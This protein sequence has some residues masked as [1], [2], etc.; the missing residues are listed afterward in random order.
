MSQCSIYKNT[1][2]GDLYPYDIQNGSIRFNIDNKSI[3]SKTITNNIDLK[4]FIFDPE[5]YWK[6]A[7]ITDENLIF[8]KAILGKTQVQ[9]KVL[10]IEDA[11][12][13][14][15]VLKNWDISNNTRMSCN[16]FISSM[17]G[18]IEPEYG[19]LFWYKIGSPQYVNWDNLSKNISVYVTQDVVNDGVKLLSKGSLVT[20]LSDSI[21][22]DHSKTTYVFNN[23]SVD[24]NNRDAYVDISS[25]TDKDRFVSLSNRNISID[26]STL[27]DIWI[28][29]GEAL[30][31]YNNQTEKSRYNQSGICSYSYL[32][33]GLF[34][35]YRE[36]YHS[37]TKRRPKGIAYNRK[38]AFALQKLC[39]FLSTGPFFDR[40]TTDILSSIEVYNSVQEYIDRFVFNQTEEKSYLNTLLLY[41]GEKFAPLH[42]STSTYYCSTYDDL[43]KNILNKYSAIIP[44]AGNETVK[45]KYKKPISNHIIV[46]LG[47]INTFNKQEG[48]DTVLY[49]N[50]S[51]KVGSL[52]CASAFTDKVSAIKINKYSSSTDIEKSLDIPLAD[53]AIPSVTVQDVYAGGVINIPWNT[54]NNPFGTQNNIPEM[55][56]DHNIWEQVGADLNEEGATYSWEPYGGETCIKFRDYSKD[57][58]IFGRPMY[59]PIR[60]FNTSI[61]P[62]PML[63]LR[64]SGTYE[65]K[66]TRT[67]YRNI[68]QSDTVI[69][70]TDNNTEIR[71]TDFIPKTYTFNKNCCSSFKI[72]AFNQNGMIW[73][74][75]TDNYYDKG[76]GTDND[77][78]FIYGVMRLRDIKLNLQPADKLNIK[79][80]T[81]NDFV[82][83]F[84][85]GTAGFWLMSAEIEY[86]RDSSEDKVSC[87]SFYREK[88]A[89]LKRN[90][91]LVLGSSDFGR[92][93]VNSYNFSSK[94]CG[95]SENIK[96]ISFEDPNP[97]T[98]YA[99]TIYSYGGYSREEVDAI[100][101]TIP[102][103]PK[104]DSGTECKKNL[105]VLSSRNNFKE[106]PDKE[107]Y[108][109]PEEVPY[110]VDSSIDLIPGHFNPQT[111]WE[112]TNIG[113]TAVVSDKASN[114]QCFT[115]KGGGFYNL[116]PGGI[117]TSNIYLK[118]S[119]GSDNNTINNQ[120][121]VGGFN[122]F[123]FGNYT[124]RIFAEGGYDPW[125]NS[126]NT[127]ADN[128]ANICGS[129]ITTYEVPRDMQDKII[130]NIE[131]RLNFL[132]YFN[133]KNLKVWL[134]CPGSVINHN[135]T[136]SHSFT[137]PIDD[138][139]KNKLGLTD[140]LTKLQGL[141]SNSVTLLNQEHID[142]YQN[143]FVI[144]FSDNA[145]KF[146]ILSKPS[147]PTVSDNFQKVIYNNKICTNYDVVLPSLKIDQDNDINS[148]INAYTTKLYSINMH[149]NQ[150]TI[151]KFAGLKGKSLSD[152]KFT[153]NVQLL[154]YLINDGRLYDNLSYNDQMAGNTLT[155]NIP[156][157]NVSLNSLCSWEIVVYLKDI[158]NPVS[159]NYVNGVDYSLIHQD[160]YSPYVGYD[161]LMK[162]ND[163]Q[164]M[165][166]PLVNINA[167]YASIANVNRCSY[168]EESL[169]KSVFTPRAEFP[170]LIPYLTAGLGFGFG[171][172]VGGMVAL[173]ALNHFLSNGGRND[174]IIN[175][176][177]ESRLLNQTETTNGAYYKPVYDRKYFGQ[178][179]RA[180]ICLSNNGA[181]W[182]AIEVPIF[183]YQNTPAMQLKKYKYIKL[184]KDKVKSLSNIEYKPLE[185]VSDIEFTIQPDN[186]HYFLWY[187]K[188]LKNI[189]YYDD[190]ENDKQSD[191]KKGTYILLDGTRP[192]RV[193]S[194]NEEVYISTIDKNAVIMNMALVSTK[195]GNK[196]IIELSEKINTAGYIT[197]TNQSDTI[198]LYDET[199]TSIIDESKYF[200][201]WVGES[202]Y[203]EKISIDRNPESYK[204]AYSPG[205]I[206]WGTNQVR[207][208]M[209][210]VIDYNKSN[211]PLI[212]LLNNHSDKY[213]K[214]TLYLYDN[215]DDTTPIQTIYPIGGPDNNGMVG[216]YSSLDDFGYIQHSDSVPISTGIHTFYDKASPIL[217][218]L[219][220]DAFKNLPVSGYLSLENDFI[221]NNKV[222][223]FLAQKD[224]LESRLQDIN[225][226]ISDKMENYTDMEEDD[227]ECLLGIIQDCPKTKLKQELTTLV[228]ERKQILNILEK[229]VFNGGHLNLDFGATDVNYDK[230]KNWYWITIDPEQPS[231][232]VDEMTVK[233]PQKLEMNAIP[234]VGD[235]VEASRILPNYYAKVG[236]DK[237]NAK[238]YFQSGNGSYTYTTPDSVIESTKNEMKTLYPGLVWEKDET[239]IYGT[240]DPGLGDSKKLLIG[241]GDSA[242]DNLISFKETYIRP[243]G[244]RDLDNKKIKDVVNLGSN[245]R[246]RFRNMPRQLQSVDSEDFDKYVYDFKGNI[247]RGIGTNSRARSVGQLANNFVCWKCIDKDGE[248]V[249]PPP[250]IK[251]MNEMHYRAFF[252]SVDKIEHKSESMDSQYAWEW[253]PYEF[254]GGQCKIDVS[255]WT[256]NVKSI[257]NI[258]KMSSD[259]IIIAKTI[260]T[261]NAGSLTSVNFNL[262]L[263]VGDRLVT[264]TDSSC[265]G[266][267]G[268]T[269]YTDKFH[270]VKCISSLPYADIGIFTSTVNAEGSIIYSKY[271]TQIYEIKLSASIDDTF[272]ATDTSAACIDLSELP[273]VTTYIGL[274]SASFASR[275]FAGEL[276]AEESVK[277]EYNLPDSTAHIMLIGQMLNGCS[278]NENIPIIFNI[279]AQDSGSH[280]IPIPFGIKNIG[281]YIQGDSGSNA[282]IS[283]E[284]I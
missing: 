205:T 156:I 110:S 207:P 226:T 73:L 277:I 230:Y 212:D 24:F 201:K 164:K 189:Q 105:P 6:P 276:C 138:D 203:Q 247:S 87:K 241:L 4:Q 202:S 40:T 209:L 69:I 55:I 26:S 162:L 154:D 3:V 12:S 166:L 131:V 237:E 65:L 160:S 91:K 184:N 257:N 32:S 279:T 17:F 256:N 214:N 255:S 133:P 14:E 234:I 170:S 246:A 186:S 266:S 190:T 46:S 268:T 179:D 278:C 33:P 149:N 95:D 1:F 94:S 148:E 284:C 221:E 123:I 9:T 223:V 89:R 13:F 114:Q 171:S 122:S 158:K 126:S 250:F 34:P 244:T 220:Y 231:I 129:Q 236:S 173:S 5:P 47:T 62:D 124:S 281:L 198:L 172:I 238:R 261:N 128:S 66:V 208:E 265:Y 120:Y 174:P 192:F 52:E 63:F 139:I 187:N 116:R 18:G 180:I 119:T 74:V 227:I 267:S 37:L 98:C 150:Q 191:L 104:P 29:P 56:L 54:N 80:N 68:V 76:S 90:T 235:R 176:F 144:T 274:R 108:C 229:S 67:L 232:L 151:Y 23:Q 84:S 28:S 163:N 185:E 243:L 132:N 272:D 100:G 211:L 146:K 225:Q 155:E 127:D 27:I 85:G 270:I 38:Q 142:N 183:R 161:Y 25:I 45:L 64:K 109:F 195:T 248:F 70:T 136:S 79:S 153:L 115:F 8:N 59:P 143:N 75:D 193:F 92:I 102:F 245:L 215:I 182:H 43:T 282:N 106:Q 251:T 258:V 134:T 200:A 240:T 269:D 283:A 168:N 204:S 130:E 71:K 112:N 60:M 217:V 51:I 99:P 57:L 254:Y 20:K 35:I 206:G 218:E 194:L 113:K 167:P 16:L 233:I 135:T 42:Q 222:N 36:I 210:Y 88:I 140:Y 117:Y 259:T 103:H 82:L 275:A 96:D 152:C 181:F 141:H 252:G 58:N 224:L 49:N 262:N 137:L 61:N 77:D 53:I 228:T 15:P 216:W 93:S 175:Y 21:V 30:S 165:L 177:I 213:I 31:Y 260:V 44:V 121:G 199:K 197:K 2:F 10:G 107:I 169:G 239:F 253:I 7:Y 78:Y 111:G 147:Y 86:M 159:K 219:K 22:Y 97:S 264:A 101:I 39:Y 145:D 157:S 273:N 188:H 196:T 48:S 83:S 11:I 72:T 242:R 41:M 280:T 81:E 50:T 271:V 178:A 249:E 263:E 118:P 19:I 125:F